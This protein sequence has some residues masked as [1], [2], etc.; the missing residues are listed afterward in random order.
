MLTHHIPN[1]NNTSEMEIPKWWA[2]PH[3]CSLGATDF[4]LLDAT[5]EQMRHEVTEVT[6]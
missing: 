2:Y 1:Q 3:K 4:Y 5:K 6:S